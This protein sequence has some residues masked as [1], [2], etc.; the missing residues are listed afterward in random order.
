MQVVTLDS[1]ARKLRLFSVAIA[2]V[3]G[4]LVKHLRFHK[5]RR[6]TS[7]MMRTRRGQNRYH[8]VVPIL[9]HFTNL[10][11][12]EIE[13]YQGFDV[14][15]VLNELVDVFQ[16]VALPITAVTLTNA[17]HISVRGAWIADFL[18]ALP[19]LSYLHLGGITIRDEELHAEEGTEA[20]TGSGVFRAAITALPGLKKL[21]LDDLPAPVLQGL[22]LNCD[23]EELDVRHCT[24]VDLAAL[25]TLAMQVRSTLRTLTFIS[26][27]ET[28]PFFP[29]FQLTHL[30]TLNI[31]APLPFFVFSG[32]SSSP[33]HTLR[34]S[35]LSPEVTDEDDE[36]FA[37]L[38]Q[39]MEEN[40]ASLKRLE[41]RLPE[42]QEGEEE[43]WRNDEA[44]ERLAASCQRRGVQL[45]LGGAWWKERDFVW[46]FSIDIIAPSNF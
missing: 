21:V 17:S 4:H 43:V 41:V 7:T 1:S 32:F 15:Q 30:S 42:V 12:F 35:R 26:D 31:D 2:P 16:E 38:E 6:E 5:D 27:A 39:V 40:R 18:S 28:S 8:A 10:E 44:W 46:E 14:R 45:K 20:Q 37:A 24:D 25:R 23:L 36:D 9:P 29:A 3:H 19:K 11:H 13:L 22:Q 34:S 33:L